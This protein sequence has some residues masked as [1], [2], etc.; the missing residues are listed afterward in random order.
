MPGWYA[1]N[2]TLE[3]TIRSGITNAVF[4]EQISQNAFAE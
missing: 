4:P 3:I 2:H 1:Y